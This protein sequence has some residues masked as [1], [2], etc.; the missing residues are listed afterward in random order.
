MALSDAIAAELHA[1]PGPKCSIRTVLTKLNPEDHT[2]L[3][4]A[5]QTDHIP[6]AAIARALKAEGHNIGE[7]TVARHRKHGCSCDTR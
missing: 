4:Q 6:S 3:T 5:L 7:S 2:E 1:M